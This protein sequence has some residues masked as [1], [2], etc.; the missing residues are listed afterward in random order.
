MKTM[1]EPASLRELVDRLQNITP[2]S[3]REWETMTP[4]QM[5]CHLNDSFK[6]GMGEKTTASRSSW[7]MRTVVKRIALYAPMRWPQGINTLPEI[8]QKIGGTMPVDF[9]RDRDALVRT[10][11]RF[12]AAER[13]FE[14]STHPMFG[15]MS[16]SEWLRWG[17]LHTDHH[18][19]QFGA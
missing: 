8:D 17:Y 16:D 12:S 4:H 7:W 5:I 18:L 9:W 3:P 15:R 19:R 14:W 13:D 11:T 10:M 6:V 2:L 1:R